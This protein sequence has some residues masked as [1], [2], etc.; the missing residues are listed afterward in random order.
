M[1]P[2]TVILDE[3][4]APLRDAVAEFAPV[5]VFKSARGFL[6]HPHLL[7]G[8]LLDE[9]ARAETV[10]PYVFTA[11]SFGGFA[12]LD[13]AHRYPARLAGLVLLDASH[14]DQGPAALAA[15]PPNEPLTPGLVAFRRLMEGF[16]P[17]WDESCAAIR[18]IDGLGDLPLRVLAAGQLDMPAGLSPATREALIQG[19]HGLQRRHAALSTR[20][21]VQIIPGAGHDLVRQAPEA[22]VAAIRELVALSP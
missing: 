1:P 21:T 4:C 3:S 19:W 5:L 11:A 14:P 2:P 7:V 8:D 16:G 17:V 15:I 9:L 18:R 22:V 10:P 6:S 13:Y 12:A 20:G